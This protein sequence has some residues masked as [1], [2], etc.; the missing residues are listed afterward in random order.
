M[1]VKPTPIKDLKNGSYV[2]V[3]GE[4]C[5][6]TD[7]TKSKPGKHGST[8]ARVEVMGI[9]DNKRRYILKPTSAMIDVPIIDKKKAQVISV[10]GD[11][12]QLMDLEDYSTFE[13]T[14]PDEF[15]GKIDTG[16]EVEYWRLENRTLIKAYKNA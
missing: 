4:P 8:K 16:M 7:M 2:M 10:E 15:K 11:I 14:V 12:V 13:T 6:V 5:K 9:F 1:A 3:D